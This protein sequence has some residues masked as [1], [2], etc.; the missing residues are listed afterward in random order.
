MFDS[1]SDEQLVHE[2][3][4]GEQ[5]AFTTLF[6]RYAPLVE[7][8]AVGLPP[9]LES[10]DLKQEGRMG[11]LSA[12]LTFDPDCGVPFRAYASVCVSHQ[13]ASARRVAMKHSMLHSPLSLNSD[14]VAMLE[15]VPDAGADPEQQV[16]EWE[17]ASRI[18][19]DLTER[20]SPLEKKSLLLYLSGSTYEEIAD[21]VGCNLKAIDNALQRVRRKL[22]SIHA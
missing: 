21:K 3:R 9:G 16:I 2:A 20:L 8:K 14:Q 19:K 17:D 18:Y 7:S 12:V 11:L 15:E 5:E 13:V 1:I 22:R 6:T 10:D 4:R